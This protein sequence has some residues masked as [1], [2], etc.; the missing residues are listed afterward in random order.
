MKYY[1]TP[2]MLVTTRKTNKI[3]NASMMVPLFRFNEDGVYETDDPLMIARLNG[4]FD[5][6]DNSNEVIEKKETFTCKYCNEEFESKGKLL[7][8]YKVCKKKGK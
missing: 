5:C 6:I 2:N 1:G 3:T 7:A 4:R 8:H